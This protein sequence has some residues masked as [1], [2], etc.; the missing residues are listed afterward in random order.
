VGCAKFAITNSGVCSSV[1]PSSP[2]LLDISPVF[3]SKLPVGDKL[4]R[5][6]HRCKISTAGATLL[7]SNV[8][9]A[10]TIPAGRHIK[11]TKHRP[12]GRRRELN[13]TFT[14]TRWTDKGMSQGA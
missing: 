3:P 5:S 6:E 1:E 2:R 12:P 10:N 8:L 14:L 13:P 7:A 9:L 11:A 4:N